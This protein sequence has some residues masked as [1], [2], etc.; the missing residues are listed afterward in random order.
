MQPSRLVEDLR[1]W[2]AELGFAQLG[3]ANIDLDAEAADFNAWLAQGFH[4]EMS[5][6]Q[7]HGARRVRPAELVQGT[8]ACISV[9]MNYW[10]A[11]SADAWATLAD[12]SKAYVSRYALGRDYHKVLRARLRALAERLRAQVG[13]VGYRVFSDSAPVLEKPLARSAGLGWIGKHTNLIDRK[14]GSYF[15]LGEIY[16]DLALPPDPP[17]SAHC[18]TCAACLPACPTRAIVAPYRLDARRCISY[19]TIELRGAIP[20]EFRAA[21]GNRVYGC[22]DCQLV[23]PW[24]K[25]AQASNENDFAV[26]N[27]LDDSTLVSLFA[28]NEAHFLRAMQGSA[29][30]RIGYER[31]LRNL[32]VGLGNAPTSTAV[33]DALRT[34]ESDS[35]ALVREHVQWALLRHRGQGSSLDAVRQ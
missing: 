34:R 8:V 9:R 12:P 3:I 22:D 21:I 18:G 33:I 19:L 29:I 25:F 32:A 1:R 10:P 6:M 23:C 15:F 35:S 30:R 26:R 2:S 20:M 27:G 11:G 4:G 14:S 16:V 28:W 5:Y 17:A 24:N 7:R 31:W 13:P